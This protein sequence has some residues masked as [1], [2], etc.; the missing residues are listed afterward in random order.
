MRAQLVRSIVKRQLMVHLAWGWVLAGTQSVP[1]VSV[2]MYWALLGVPHVEVLAL[3]EAI[4][5][6]VLLL[7]AH[8]RCLTLGLA[9]LAVLV[10]EDHGPRL[11][12]SVVPRLRILLGPRQRA[13]PGSHPWAELSPRLR[14]ELGPRLR[15]ERTRQVRAPLPQALVAP[16]T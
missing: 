8:P 2:V 13:V 16:S 12:F 4:A 6:V 7:L 15:T 3:V 5:L 9:I 14:T 1:L 10:S 11:R